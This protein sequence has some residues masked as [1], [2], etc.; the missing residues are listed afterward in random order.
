MTYPFWK[1]VGPPSDPYSW[2]F[3]VVAEIAGRHCPI[4]VVSSLGSNTDD[5]TLQ[6]PALTATCQRI[7]TIFKNP[8]NHPAVRAELALAAGYY[9]RHDDSKYLDHVELP[10]LNRIMSQPT[11]RRM[12]PWYSGMQEFPFTTA[13]LLNGVGFDAQQGVSNTAQPEPLGTVY[14]D[15]SIEWGMVVIDIT[16]LDAIH[17]GIVGFNVGRMKL[18]TSRLN[19]GNTMG[20]AGPGAFEPG[21]LRVMDEVR[22]RRAMS[23]AE[24]LAKFKHHHETLPT[25]DP[26]CDYDNSKQQQLL[27][28]IPLID[29]A[30]MR[31]VW[32][33]KDD[34]HRSLP[35]LSLGT[36]TTTTRSLPDQA[37]TSLIQSTFNTDDFEMSIFDEVRT[38]P[39]F[40]DL[41]WRN[42]VQYSARLGNTRSAGQLIRL[43]FVD[44]EHLSL[45]QL[46]H[47]SAEAISAALDVSEMRNITSISLCIDSI[48]STPAQLIDVL[49][50]ADTLQDIYFLQSPTRESDMLSVQLFEELAV[51]PQ[52]LLRATV[53]LA[54]AYS[55]ALRKKFW[56]PTIP[57]TKMSN[58]ANAVQIAPLEVFPI[59]QMLIRQSGNKYIYL[60]DALLR[61]ERFAAGFLLFLHSLVP[62]MDNF[63]NPKAQL[64]SFS[65]AP[66]SL[67]DDTLTTAEISPIPAESFAISAAECWP[68]VRD[69]IPS[70]WTV[71]VSQEEHWD[72]A[73]AEFNR[74]HSVAHFPQRQTRAYFIQYAF[75]RARNQRIVVDLPSLMPPG[76]EELEVVGLKEFLNIT[77]RKVDSAVVD[78]RLRD[79]AEA[80]KSLPYQGILPPGTEPISV[81]SHAEAADMLLEFLEDARNVK[82]RLRAAMEENSEGEFFYRFAMNYI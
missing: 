38:L 11:L 50:R 66:S 28:S 13:C 5:W 34:I 1:A 9:T 15:T 54:G 61:P 39:S 10:E 58:I 55:A 53:M 72:R 65:S 56:L 42:L 71:I 69:L 25:Y 44:Q 29:D 36:S 21:E 45:E 74:T 22:P 20:I 16:K 4:A 3:F 49:S 12:R 47:L 79:V 19:E 18:V 43:A 46:N 26:N 63:L 64:F 32:P 48:R 76:L 31:L 75:V 57:K 41:L 7:V 30:A 17:Y 27:A 52:V 24:Y 37:I 8:T 51:R 60:G 77:A 73:A 81:L 70:G 78:C 6:G 82:K 23:A 80:L 62:S 59:Q 67:T 40:Q 35:A 14:R 68:L 2:A 33:Q